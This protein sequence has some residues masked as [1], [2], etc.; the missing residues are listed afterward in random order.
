M[1]NHEKVVI[2]AAHGDLDGHLFSLRTHLLSQREFSLLTFG[3][4]RRVAGVCD[5]IRKELIEVEESNGDLKE[6]VDVIILAFDGALRT[7]THPSDIIQAIVEKQKINESR[8]WPDW[9]TVAPDQAIEHV[10]SGE[11]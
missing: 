4:F 6:W 5:H 9:R 3:P 10:I 7:G 2:K 1:D 11:K 8:K